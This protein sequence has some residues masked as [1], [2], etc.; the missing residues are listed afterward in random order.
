[1]RKR[2]N[3]FYMYAHASNA[4]AQSARKAAGKVLKK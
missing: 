2:D 1:M 4:K 3:A